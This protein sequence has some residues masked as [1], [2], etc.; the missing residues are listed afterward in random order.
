MTRPSKDER[1]RA[2][3]VRVANLIGYSDSRPE[4]QLFNFLGAAV[5]VDL[6]E[7]GLRLRANEALPIGHVLRLDLKLGS[8]VHSLRGR[9]VW[10][11]ELEEDT[12]YD[13]GV[14]F[15]ELTEKQQEVLRVFVSVKSAGES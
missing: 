11:E 3:R 1:R 14:R 10:G 8:D 6:S 7:S 9:I 4:K 13:F 5:T 12:A 2:P 15:I